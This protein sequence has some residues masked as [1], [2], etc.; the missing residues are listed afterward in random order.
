[1]F[2]MTRAMTNGMQEVNNLNSK[3]GYESIEDWQNHTLACDSIF[4]SKSEVEQYFRKQ[5]ANAVHAIFLEES[6]KKHKLFGQILADN[7]D[8]VAA[9]FGITEADDGLSQFILDMDPDDLR[10]FARK[11]INIVAKRPLVANGYF[12]YKAWEDEI[13]K[14]WLN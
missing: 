3:Y 14:H 11:I 4:Y 12:S 13:K 7:Y 5:C 10:D 2:V 9:E 8:A 1:M 6:N